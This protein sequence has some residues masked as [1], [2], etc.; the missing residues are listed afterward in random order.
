MSDDTQVIEPTPEQDRKAAETAFAIAS[1]EAPVKAAAETP[2]VKVV[3]E[4]AVKETVVD[5]WDGVPVVVRET[6]Q[7][8]TKQFGTFAKVFNEHKA[9]YGR[10]AASLQRIEAAEA[11]AK[12]VKD[13]PTSAQIA[14]AAEDDA[15]WKQIKEDFPDWA[16]VQEKR[17][18]KQEAFLRAEIAKVPVVDVEVMRKQFQAEASAAISK[19]ASVIERR[20]REF[21]RVDAKYPDWDIDIHAP[22]G[23]F[24]PEFAA[25]EKTQAPEIKALAASENSR[26]AIKMLDLYYDHRKT[27]DT[28]LKNQQRLE[29]A[30]PAKGTQ[31]QRQPT[32]TEREAAERAFASV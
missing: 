14:A 20:A 29:S 10:I 8:V 18:A 9:D 22:T 5:P 28:R 27:E 26:D 24:T 4:P 13:A 7:G 32:T 3:E 21:A 15:E 2:E 19:S 11:A 6:L 1:D 12:V 25:W 17:E 31:G 16:K 23:G 30:I